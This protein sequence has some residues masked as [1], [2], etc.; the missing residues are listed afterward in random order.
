MKE[1]LIIN[2]DGL[3]D[4]FQFL[5]YSQNQDTSTYIQELLYH[6]LQV[7]Q[8]SEEYRNMEK[9]KQQ[10]IIKQFII[11]QNLFNLVN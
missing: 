5:N 10:A 4:N 2:D 9:I 8:T 11:N 6:G 1:T 3:P 7:Y